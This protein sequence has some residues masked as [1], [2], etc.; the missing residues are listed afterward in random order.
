MQLIM[1][2]VRCFSGPHEIPIKPLMLLIGENSSGKT[3]MFARASEQ[4]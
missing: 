4:A 1:E 2:N 3:T